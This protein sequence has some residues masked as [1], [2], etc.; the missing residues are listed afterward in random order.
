MTWNHRVLAHLHNNEVYF[1]IH[2]VRY[3]DTDNDIP[4]H[5]THNAV[6]IGGEDIKSL[7]WTLN[8]MQES[9]KKPILWA[10]E[11]FPQE[12][13]ITYKCLHCGRDK[14]KSKT[15]HNCRNNFRKRNIIWEIKCV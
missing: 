1:Q 8:K 4:K 7:K 12:A 6:S 15:S 14:F 11:K 2:E 3:D 13:I 9:L 10:G 5:Y